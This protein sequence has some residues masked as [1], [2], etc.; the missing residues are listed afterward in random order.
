MTKGNT[1]HTNFAAYTHQQLYAMLQAG[2]P[3]TARAAAEK[4][5]ST[6]IG[7]YE[8]G[9]SLCRELDDFDDNWSGG[10]ADKYKTMITDLVGG[11][12]KVGQTAAAMEHLLEDAA[13]ALVKAKAEMPPPVNVP[14]VP[15]AQVALATTPV[16]LPPNAPPET[17]SAIAQQR[18][19]AIAVVEAQQA[20]ASA[21]SA[22]HSKAILVMTSLAGEY[23]SAED[24]IPASPNAATPPPGVVG[25]GTSTGTSGPIGNGMPGIAPVGTVVDPGQPHILPGEGTN[26]LPPGSTTPR[27]NP[28]FGDMF[29]AGLAAASAA[30]FGRF[31]SIMPK[32]PGWAT[33]KNPD[34][35]KDSE[36]TKLGGGASGPGGG[37]APNM[38]GMGAF[39]GGG[40]GIDAGSLGGAATGAMPAAH[41]GL[42]GSPD[43][44]NTLGSIAGGAAGGAAAAAGKGMM[45]MMP[46]MPMTG[47]GNDMGSGRRIPPWLVETEDVW[48]QSAP[49]A[50][51]V[52][53][54]DTEGR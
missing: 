29:T 22:A 2:D 26:L 49:I 25:G 23:T 35:E 8:S 52:I 11:I 27:S 13:D 17:V 15:P 34:E 21:A 14:D 36:S 38:G 7:L 20:A 51:S 47:A 41:S 33:G 43:V 5:K 18:Q 39:G 44:G 16:M 9:D 46:M 19:Q 30:A 42:A 4:W 1:A 24:S 53:G 45:P 54:E 10:A 28:L 32:V 6:A 37:E 31:G 3:H 40:G 12:K 48:G 50:P